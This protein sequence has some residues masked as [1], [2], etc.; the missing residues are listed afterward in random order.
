MMQYGDTMHQTK[1]IETETSR[2]NPLLFSDAQISFGIALIK[3]R[4]QTLYELP[5]GYLDYEVSM[6]ET[7]LNNSDGKK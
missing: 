3:N 6:M 5:E 2:E 4:G 7:I 1:S